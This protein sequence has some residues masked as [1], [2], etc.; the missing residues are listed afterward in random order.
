MTL[1]HSVSGVL[2]GWHIVSLTRELGLAAEG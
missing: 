2:E 1:L